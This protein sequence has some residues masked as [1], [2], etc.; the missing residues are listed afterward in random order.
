VRRAFLL[1]GLVLASACGRLSFE[2]TDPDAGR[3]ATP[4]DSAPVGLPTTCAELADGT[5]C[6]DRN[7]CSDRSTCVS[8]QCETASPV[9]S[10]ELASSMTDFGSVQGE[11]GWTYGFYRPEED[12]DGSY[13]PSD[14]RAA[15]FLDEAWRPPDYATKFTWTYLM[16]WGGHP[17]TVVPTW[18]I[19]RWTSATA[20]P[21]VVRLEASKSD[22]SCEA[23]LDHALAVCR[24]HGLGVRDVGARRWR[25]SA[26]H[27]QAQRCES[28]GGGHEC[29]FT[30]IA[31]RTAAL[32]HVRAAGC[33]TMAPWDGV[34]ACW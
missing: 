16:A 15:A 29:D 21:A 25:A 5:L 28:H 11:R 12:A 4:P 34:P 14:F 6:D 10:C 30:V 13:A 20:G 2:A 8:G 26:G 31:R 32:D 19:R 17:A 1:P 22:A 18:P 33:S 24:R 3:D 27:E 23:L 9:A 7:A